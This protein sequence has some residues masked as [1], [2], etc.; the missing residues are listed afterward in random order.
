MGGVPR[1]CSLRLLSHDHMVIMW[2]GKW[3]PRP[4]LSYYLSKFGDPRSYAEGF[5]INRS[6]GI[7]IIVIIIFNIII[8]FSVDQ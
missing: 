8:L 3:G 6:Q 4:T 1:L 7:T 5:A 2:L